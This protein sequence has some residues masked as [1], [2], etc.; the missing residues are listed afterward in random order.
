MSQATK[1]RISKL[2]KDIKSKTLSHDKLIESIKEIGVKGNKSLA[3]D[4]IPLLDEFDEK[5]V[6]TNLKDTIKKM[7]ITADFMNQEGIKKEDENDFDGAIR[8]YELCVKLDPKHKWAWYNMARMYNNQKN[9]K[10]KAIELYKEAVSVDENYGDAWNN[11]GNVYLDLNQLSL[12]KQAYERTLQSKGYNFKHF[13]YYN[14]GLVY[15]RVNNPKKALDFFLKALQIKGDYARALYHTG[16]TYRILEEHEKASEYFALALEH[17]K[18]FEK[19]IRDL[20][21]VMEEVITKQILRKL[22]K[23]EPDQDKKGK[24]FKD[25]PAKPHGVRKH[26]VR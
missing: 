12:A 18:H 23:F 20:G 25:K 5:D 21:V 6:I 19:S 10:E 14:L 16:K 7:G 13:P 22:D 2:I 8:M 3:D 4:L 15:N 26:G 9:N 1:K 17:D 11:M 24:K